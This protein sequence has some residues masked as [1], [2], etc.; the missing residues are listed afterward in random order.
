MY[1]RYRAVW[2]PPMTYCT[3]LQ[4]APGPPPPHHTN[5]TNTVSFHNF[6]SQDF[7]MSVSKPEEY[8]AYFSVL[9][10]ISNC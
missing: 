1:I 5:N 7:K 2:A 6:K 4:H 8:V 10:Q 9:S 3:V